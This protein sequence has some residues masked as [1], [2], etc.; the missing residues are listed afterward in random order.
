M[1]YAE[2]ILRIRAKFT[3]S[4]RTKVTEF[5]STLKREVYLSNSKI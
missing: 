5:F 4:R 3:D 2:Q 1:M